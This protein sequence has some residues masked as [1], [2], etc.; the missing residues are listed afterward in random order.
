MA[1]S[2][3]ESTDELLGLLR[4]SPN[5][6]LRTH[7]INQ[8]KEVGVPAAALAAWLR[9]AQDRGIQCGLMMAI[10][11]YPPAQ[12]QNVEDAMGLVKRIFDSADEAG[13][14]AT[15]S[16]L[17][18][19][20][21]ED[22]GPMEALDAVPG[23][24]RDADSA[25]ITQPSELNFIRIDAKAV[26]GIERVYSIADREISIKQFREFR[27]N[28]YFSQ[29]FG[30]SDLCPANV[31]EWREAIAYCNW[32]SKRAGFLPIYP[33]TDE[34][35]ERWACSTEELSK[36]G[37]RLPTVAEWE[38]ACRGGTT[39]P[40]H[41]GTDVRLLKYYA[42]YE[43]DMRERIATLGMEEKMPKSTSRAC[44]SFATE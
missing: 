7:L 23:P 40:W 35:A 5:P 18:R 34:E 33:E 37:Y 17:L 38:F 36:P 15:A 29:E 2:H 4:R 16:W 20:W 32:L 41:F 14:Q 9:K 42:V 25:K 12:L 3:S 1:Q 44:G 6:T 43:G 8:L 11:E 24:T 28:E 22:T 27:S 21:G 10:G 31:V 19:R 30:P 39:T 26:P 13:V